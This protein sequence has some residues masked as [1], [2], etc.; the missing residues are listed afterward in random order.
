MVSD[1]RRVSPMERMRQYD[2]GIYKLHQQGMSDER[3]AGRVGDK[4]GR[5]RAAI[6]R[7]SKREHDLR[8]AGGWS[9]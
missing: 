6:A 7:E 4:V 2:K 8:D 5:V 9:R 1:E 3:I